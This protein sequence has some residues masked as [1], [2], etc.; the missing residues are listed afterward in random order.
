M[1]RSR[2]TIERYKGERLVARVLHSTMSNII[3]LPFEST[4]TASYADASE[5]AQ[6][7]QRLEHHL[8]HVVNICV[9]G[10]WASMGV[11]FH[12]DISFSRFVRIVACSFGGRAIA[13]E[14][15]NGAPGA[16]EPGDRGDDGSVA[17]CAQL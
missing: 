3:P 4:L 14:G 5:L 7:M 15:V 6:A 16:G 10:K 9:T 13:D 1:A 8:A 11:W 17:P 2:A 12:A